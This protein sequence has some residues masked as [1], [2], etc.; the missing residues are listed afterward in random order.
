MPLAPRLS[1]FE[2]WQQQ[3]CRR[4]DAVERRLSM[5]SPA[6]LGSSRQKPA[7]TISSTAAALALR[8]SLVAVA[9]IIDAYKPLGL[10][11]T[12]VDLSLIHI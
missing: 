5:P 9:A 2:W 3:S 6:R 4:A 12:D 7:K 1:G 11:Y 8:I 10:R